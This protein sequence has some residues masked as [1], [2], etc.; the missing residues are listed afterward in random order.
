MYN[1][2]DNLKIHNVEYGKYLLRLI[3]ADYLPAEIAWRKVKVGGIVY[4]FN[5]KLGFMDKGEFNKEKYLEMQE[6]ILNGE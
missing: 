2:P 5:K 3:A 6:E 1:L 4:P